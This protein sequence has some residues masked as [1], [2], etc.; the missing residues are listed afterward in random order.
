MA[1]EKDFV[2]EYLNFWANA[3]NS[4]EAA[5][6]WQNCRNWTKFHLEHILY[7]LA[8]ELGYVNKECKKTQCTDYPFCTEEQCYGTYIQKEYYRVDLSLYS[9]HGKYW[10]LDYA[11][12]HENKKY[13]FDTNKNNGWFYEFLKI[14]PLKCAKARVV[15]GY[16]D[17]K[18]KVNDKIEKCLDVL[19]KGGIEESIADSKIILIIFP[20]SSC[21]KKPEIIKSSPQDLIRIVKFTKKGNSWS[22]EPFY[23]YDLKNL[24]ERYKL[25]KQT[26]QLK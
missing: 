2:S 9:Y 1:E 13:K 21:L 20:S 12:E 24:A 15:I 3:V 14:L 11:I 23:S 19:N 16:D 4:K 25:I 8:K 22:S 7:P 6:N 10:T 5:A 26:L 18:E 17:F